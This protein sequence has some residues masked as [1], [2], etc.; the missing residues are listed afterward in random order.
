MKKTIIP[1]LFLTAFGFSLATADDVIMTINGVDVP[2]SEFEYLYHKNNQQQLS[3]QPIEEYLEL[4][5][6]YK[7]KVA[8][9]KDAG[10]DTTA[11]F[12]KEINQYRRE[13]AMPYMADSAYMYSFIDIEAARTGEEIEASH[14]MLMRSRDLAENMKNRA[15]LDSIRTVILN[16]GDF[17]DLAVRFS[18]DRTVERNKG[19]MGYI[20][21]GKFPYEFETALWETPEGELSEVIESPAG[22]HLIKAGHRRPSKGRV[23]AAHIMKMVPQNASESARLKA[24]ET[25]DSLYNIVSGSPQ[26]FGEIARLNSDDK[27]SAR[28][29]G[30][31]PIFGSGEMVPEFEAVA[32]ALEDGEISE[33]VESQYGWHII[34]KISSKGPAT[35]EELKPVVMRALGNPQDARF[36]MVKEHELDLIK[37]KHNI[38][39]NKETVDEMVEQARKQGIDSLYLANWTTMPNSIKPVAH[40]GK[41]EIPASDVISNIKVTNEANGEIA[42]KMISDAIKIMLAKLAYEAEEDWL[43]ANN[44]DYRNLMNE[45]TDGSLLY[46][47]SLEKVWDKAA[48]DN[49]GLENYF[50]THRDRYKFEKPRVKGYLVQAMNDS[51]SNMVRARMS[52]MKNDSELQGIQKDFSGK[53]NIE[54]I[55]VEQGANAM[56]DN[57]MFGG[58]KAKPKFANF[59]TYF[60]FEPRIIEAPEE[61]WD[62]R[63][64]VTTDY[65]AELEEVWVKELVKKYPVKVNKKVLSKVK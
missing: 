42:S 30:K 12:K 14:I 29:D 56:V 22:F 26:R 41:R 53:A 64:T 1:G 11:N 59:T 51:I 52:E 17:T 24:K 65:Q 34:Q 4:F 27:G 8:A 9:A 60:L 44:E 23:E 2:K 28:S 50:N 49:E 32:F 15:I 55:I 57:I 58:E 20:G 37:Q 10:I 13:L 33:P 6:I 63:G 35:K 25:I 16:G 40:A 54:K 43:M 47:I 39:E 62:V 31:L 21:A 3:T 61:L 36:R 48:K 46:E 19:Y 7:M 45:Y 5:K 18:Q 38:A